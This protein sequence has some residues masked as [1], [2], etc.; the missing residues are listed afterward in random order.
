MGEN[1]FA[2]VPTALYG[3]VLLLAAVAYWLLQNSIIRAE[4]ANSILRHALGRDWKGKISP[5]LYIIAIF[6]TFWINWV[7]Q[8]IYAAVA[9]LWLIPDRRITR[10]LDAKD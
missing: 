9:L 10:A 8:I 3:C 5:V 7:A 6:A 2:S 4:G 1:H